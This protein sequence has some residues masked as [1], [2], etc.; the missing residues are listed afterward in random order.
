MMPHF[1]HHRLKALYPRH[2]AE[3]QA[4]G[5]GGTW[6]V[7]R[8]TLGEI[9]KGGYLLTKGEFDPGVNSVEALILSDQKTALGSLAVTW[10]EKGGPPDG[11]S[12]NSTRR[13]TG[14]NNH[15]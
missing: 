10:H 5:L 2:R 9:K 3:I 6:R 12:A 4:A 13:Q 7:F 14:G 1:P 8:K 15:I 11:A